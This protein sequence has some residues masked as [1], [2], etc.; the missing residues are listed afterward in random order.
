MRIPALPERG[1]KMFFAV[2]HAPCEPQERELYREIIGELDKDMVVFAG[3][4]FFGFEACPARELL[5]GALAV[6]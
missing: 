1:A 6:R 5:S 2:R 3:R 4:N